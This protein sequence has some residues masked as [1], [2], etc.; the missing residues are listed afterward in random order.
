MCS[1][2]SSRCL[3]RHCTTNDVKRDWNCNASVATSISSE[4]HI[5]RLQIVLLLRFNSNFLTSSHPFSHASSLF[6]FSILGS[7]CDHYFFLFSPLP[8]PSIFFPSF[9]FGKRVRLLL[10][11]LL[12]PPFALY[13]FPV[14]LFWEES[15]TIALFS[16][17]S[18][19]SPSI[20]FPPFYFGKRVRLFLFSL[21]SPPFALYIIPVVLFWEE[22][23]TIAFFPSALPSLS[24]FFP[25]FY[26]GKRVQPLLFSLFS[27][28][29][30]LSM[31]HVLCLLWCE[32]QAFSYHPTDQ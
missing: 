18:V 1:A 2:I 10:F 21:L 29:F 30:G 17:L 5:Q 8:S 28:P 16:T 31:F 20:L 6:P 14:L 19:P 9:Y 11:F 23:A 15:T 3:C 4:I 32:F 24:I 12:S 13:I 7:E 25:S 26:F 27:S 22:S